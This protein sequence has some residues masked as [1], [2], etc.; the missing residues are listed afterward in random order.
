[1][2]YLILIQ[3]SFMTTQFHIINY[4]KLLDVW[5]QHCRCFH[6]YWSFQ[7]AVSTQKCFLSL[8]VIFWDCHML[9]DHAASKVANSRRNFITCRGR[10][11][12][13]RDIRELSLSPFSVPESCSR[14]QTVQPGVSW[15]QTWEEAGAW[16]VFPVSHFPVNISEGSHLPPPCKG[17]A[18][19][20]L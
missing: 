12:G 4:F 13:S 1:M 11:L 15:V 17:V 7:I 14:D 20:H 2:S 19:L 3:T 5:I 10:E 9:G 18:N 8:N 6:I 16:I